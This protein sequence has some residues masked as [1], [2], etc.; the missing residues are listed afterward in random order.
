MALLAAYAVPHPPL[1]VP[2]VGRGQEARR[3]RT[4]SPPI[5]RSP[6]AWPPTDP[7]LIVI[8]SPHAPALPRRVLHRRHAGCR[9]LA[10][11][12]RLRAAVAEAHERTR[13]DLPR[14]PRTVSA[15]ALHRRGIPSAGAPACTMADIDHAT[16]V[17]LHFLERDRRPAATV[18]V[19]RMGLSGL[20]EA[21][22]RFLGR[23]HCR[24][25]PRLGPPLR[26]RRK[27][28]RVPQAEGGRPLRVRPGR[29]R[30]RPY[31]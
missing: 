8:T 20:S 1:I 31:R 10:R 4:P 14:S 28:G 19:V 3:R 12:G 25:R 21:D 6:D 15:R 13:T 23:C 5:A 29:T 16:F 17:P 24:G 11:H 7:T 30:V 9:T 27:R 22:H 2:A 26:A 18:A